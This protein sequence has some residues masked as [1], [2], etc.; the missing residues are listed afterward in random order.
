MKGRLAIGLLILIALFCALSYLGDSMDRQTSTSGA[1]RSVSRPMAAN[2]PLP[3]TVFFHCP[4]CVE[5]KIRINLFKTSALNEVECSFLP[6]FS[7]AGKIVARSGGVVKVDFPNRCAGWI[8]S[9]LL[10]GPGLP[11]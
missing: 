4:E 7:R 5:E 6:T 1:V 2:T 11:Q 8:S 3:A 9:R 10:R